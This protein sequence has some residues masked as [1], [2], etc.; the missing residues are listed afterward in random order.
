MKIK[1]VSASLIG[2]TLLTIVAFLF[3]RR[4]VKSPEQL[5]PASNITADHPANVRTDTLKGDRFG[6]FAH[7]SSEELMRNRP[8]MHATKSYPPTNPEEVEMW[9]WWNAIDKIDPSFEWKMPVEFY[10]KV[11]DQRGEPVT[12]ATVAWTI[13][14]IVGSR[15]GT[16]SSEAGGLF[17]ISGLVGKGITVRVS[18]NGY[19]AGEGSR[20]DFEYA[21]FHED[22]FITPDSNNPVIFHL[23]KLDNPEPMYLNSLNGQIPDNGTPVA[24][25]LRLGKPVL[26]GS[27]DII[28]KFTRA[29]SPPSHE[30][31]YTLTIQAP[32]GGGLAPTNDEFMDA[33]PDLGYQTMI[34]INQPAKQ[35]PQDNSFQASHDLKFYVKTPDGKYAAVTGS[36][37]Q[38]S[39]PAAGYNFL[40]NYNPS[41]SRNLAVDMKKRLPT[42]TR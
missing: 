25:D 35:G 30:T 33:A 7:M 38:Y 16:T 36:V 19:N 9:Q 24:F 1:Y 6:R 28:V 22:G 5:K 29:Q 42:P 10:G 40:V 31:G 3:L 39:T 27:G 21:A 32:S 26:N 18:K 14:V 20:G 4:N 34:E 17:S 11:I 37:T 2:L 8:K 13:S 23:Q 15:A 12:G 41:G